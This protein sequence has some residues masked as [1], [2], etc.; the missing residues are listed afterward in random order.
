MSPIRNS[1]ILLGVVGF[2]TAALLTQITLGQV[3]KVAVP[4]LPSKD[5]EPDKDLR[6]TDAFGLNISE[7]AKK[8]INSVK[9]H[10]AG[11]D[12]M[13][14][15]DWKDIIFAL[16]SLL[17]EQRDSLYETAILD[18]KGRDTGKLRPVSVRLEVNRIIGTFPK[19][20]REFYQGEVGPVAA[21]ALKQA[22]AANNFTQL[23]EI[24]ER[25][26][27]TKAG[28][29]ATVLL[30]K[31][32]LDRGRYSAA[33]RTFERFT[34]RNPD[35]V[36]APRVLFMAALANKRLALEAGARS[37]EPTRKRYEVI[38]ENYWARLSKEIGNKDVTIS[39][40]KLTLA[41][42]ETEYK[43]PL[44]LSKPLNQND[45][46]SPRGNTANNAQGKGSRPFLEPLWQVPLMPIN[47]EDDK[48][49]KAN[50][51]DWIEQNLKQ[52]MTAMDARPNIPPIPAFFPIASSGKVIIRNYEGIYCVATRDDPV[53]GVKAGEMEW[54][55]ECE[56]SL[57]SMLTGNKRST[58]TSWWN[59]WY[60]PQ[61][62]PFGIF[63][64]NGLL[65][66][67]S[68]DGTNV[69]F[70][71]D[72]AVPPHPQYMTQQFGQF[73][74]GQPMNFGPFDHQVRANKLVALNLET[75]KLIWKAGGYST[76]KKFAPQGE[77]VPETAKSVL[78]DAL[79]LGAPMPL[80]GKLYVVLEKDREL[81]LVCLDPY[82][83]DSEKQPGLV[84]SQPLG[85]PNVSMPNDTHRRIQGINLAYSDN[86]LVCPTNA[87][88]VL[89][90][91]L[92]SHSLIWAKSYKAANPVNVGME[93]PFIG[94]RPFPQ[95]QPNQNLNQERWRCST[96]IIANGKVVFSAYDSTSVLCLN[97]RDGEQLWEV[98]RS[99]DD[100]YIAGVF[101]NRVM[102]VSRTGVR[103]LDLNDK[104]KQIGNII[105]IGTPSGVGTASKDIYYLPIK[106]APDSKDPEIWSINV[107]TGVVEAK[108]RSRKKHQ[109]GN[110]V[111][112]DGAMFSQNAFNLTC[113]PQLEVKIAEM[114]ARLKK[115]NNDPIGL[116]E[117]GDLK[118]DD[119][120]LS[121]AI[122]ILKR[123]LENKPNDD[124]K[125]KAREKLYEA[126]TE[127][128]QKDFNGGEQYLVEYKELCEVPIPDMTEP[129]KKQLLIEEELRRKSNY[130][131]LIAKGKESQGKLVEAFDNYLSFGALAGTREL[132][133]SIDQPGTLTRPDVSALDGSTTCW[134]KPL[135]S[136]APL[137][138]KAQDRWIEVQTK[139]DLAEIRGFVRVFGT[140]F[141]AGNDARLLLADKL[142]TTN[143]EDDIRE[144]ENILLSL[145]TLDE[146]VPA[147]PPSKPL[148]GF[149]FARGSW[150]MRWLSTP[151]WA[152]ITPTSRSATARRVETSSMN[153][154]PTSAS[155]LIWNR[156]ALHGRTL[157]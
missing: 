56:G 151:N 108:T 29:E 157:R 44:S 137:E 77:D 66:S 62:G 13:P 81:R 11:K 22:N 78:S 136:S 90:V 12:E 99:S 73:N 148:P 94:R 28:A 64:E 1:R 79:F 119:G 88:A 115:D 146:P 101:E 31:Y 140:R 63:F 9:K 153:S 121:E 127:L 35:E 109:T 41:Q 82:K 106:S 5:K 2:L 40:R 114:E 134:R 14:A 83:V 87:G 59:P 34:E 132:V 143:N 133:P 10:L 96:P 135:P 60:F 51:F 7:N 97:L 65:G 23:A 61:N 95:P 6:S 48:K 71:D 139:G 155:C 111:F 32:Y 110:L 27:H 113:Y 131:C 102:V 50:S 122:K 53:A 38:A 103:F 45:W 84:W 150:T 24:S 18:D 156:S 47:N 142:I 86:V 116:A 85:S 49:S 125:A 152:R 92:L 16:Q 126:I 54:G 112:F 30:G 128:L 89:G 57:L 26:F 120:K 123:C 107:M 42:L 144:A 91:D 117:M 43:K 33:S 17:D 70:V 4:P 58:L 124:T 75:G 55:A 145:K 105:P 147:A 20:G 93:Q 67:L 149:T 154:L 25:Y 46:A 19:Q 104:G 3:K 15:E 130:F 76:N 80:G 8:K 69:Y 118:L 21:D 98:A 68:H 37:D 129:Y 74:G 52:V 100:L 36:I 72:L 39:G 138:K 141:P